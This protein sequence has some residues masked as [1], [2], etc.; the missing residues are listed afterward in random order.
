MSATKEIDIEIWKRNLRDT[1]LT[2][3]AACTRWFNN[4]F[5]FWLVCETK[6]CKRTKRCAGDADA[7]RDRFMPLVPERMKFEL[8]VMLKAVNDKLPLE[9]VMRRV[10]EE[11]ARFDE[12]TRTLERLGYGASSLSPR[13]AQRGEGG[14]TRGVAPG[15]GTRTAKSPLPSARA[16]CPAQP[17][18]EGF[19]RPR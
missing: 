2:D 10:E 8:G 5:A 16:S 1:Q 15:E 11:M 9:T 3:D 18:I 17:D 7:C 6:A 13:P 14:E 12:T 4:Y 19:R